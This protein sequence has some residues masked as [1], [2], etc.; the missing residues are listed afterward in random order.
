MAKARLGR[1]KLTWVLDGSSWSSLVFI[2]IATIFLV[3]Q[4][5]L[6]ILDSSASH[7][8]GGRVAGPPLG[9]PV[10]GHASERP[11]AQRPYGAVGIARVQ[12]VAT[13]SD[14]IWGSYDSANKLV[15][16]VD[17]NDSESDHTGEVTVVEDNKSVATL[18]V[19]DNPISSTV[20]TATGLVYVANSGSDNISL[21][22]NSSVIGSV[23][24]GFVPQA[25]YFDPADGD[26]YALQ[27]DG[28]SV[29]VVRNSSVIS[30]ITVGLDPH[31]AV[32]DPL[33]G[34]LYVANL[35]SANLSVLN[36]TRVVATVA[37]G[38][39]PGV[40]GCDDR[41]GEILVPTGGRVL[42]IVQGF[43]EVASL[44]IST[45]SASN[46]FMAV[47]DSVNGLT[48]VVDQGAGQVEIL[49]NTTVMGDVSVGSTPQFAVIDQI[50]GAVIVTALNSAWAAVIQNATLE[51]FVGT[52]LYP[53]MSVY[54][55]AHDQVD[56]LAY[57]SGQLDILKSVPFYSVT[58]YET[59]LSAGSGWTVALDGQSTVSLNATIEFSAPNG[60]YSFQISS[61]GYVP[62]PESGNLTVSGG[63]ASQS[64]SFA[65]ARELTRYA[66]T[67]LP[68]NLPPRTLWY[69][70]FNLTLTNSSTGSAIT[71][72]A[73]N[74]TYAYSS[75]SADIV[76]GN[77]SGALRVQGR[78]VSVNITFPQV[79]F[80][81]V[82]SERG[83][84]ASTNWTVSIGDQAYTGFGNFSGPVLPN[85]TYEFN[86]SEVF[87]FSSSP[88]SGNFTIDDAPTTIY[89]T[90]NNTT[91]A[92]VGGAGAF[93]SSLFDVELL[94]ASIVIAVGTIVM[95]IL[96]RQRRARGK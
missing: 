27:A 26:V 89:I 9:T 1:R 36:G 64:V 84:A 34:E 32:F 82:L 93:T 5:N 16:V 10:L 54:D 46:T 39:Y 33:S 70:T 72:I 30:T 61:Q 40:I 71:F 4:A 11:L 3:S 45:S 81:V 25:V 29:A 20:D 22:S 43:S 96:V 28:T 12:T 86:V 66:V 52:G 19:G 44:N 68:A 58:F 49:S 77:F 56:V 69:V 15:Y 95:L 63:Q 59:G 18:L 8:S 24:L 17:S 41:N 48:Y 6:S 73:A 42:T 47:F 21:L 92:G 91:A 13:G 38:G 67:F 31:S 57:G 60:S 78:G 51:N 62:T 76:F 65:S 74:G 2:P 87:G 83:L 35:E 80:Y 90:F 7:A 85:G 37:T 88:K 55:P 79:R 23:P 14:P 50:N 53:W 94:I 75:Q